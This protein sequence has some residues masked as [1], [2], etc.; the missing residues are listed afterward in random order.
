VSIWVVRCRGGGKSQTVLLLALAAARGGIFFLFSRC[1]LFSVWVAP[2]WWVGRVQ[3]C[4]SSN[5]WDG[6]R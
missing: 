5:L 2:G 1:R 3:S 6:R 4:S